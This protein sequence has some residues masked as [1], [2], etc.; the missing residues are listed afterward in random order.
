MILANPRNQYPLWPSS[1]A[2]GQWKRTH[3]YDIWTD[4]RSST[5][6]PLAL[7]EAWNDGVLRIPDKTSVMHIIPAGVPHHVEGVFGYWR[8]CE[9]DIV[10]LRVARGELTHYAMI[11]GGS[12]ADYNKDRILWICPACATTVHSVEIETGRTKL[13]EFW[14]REPAII[15]EFNADERLRTCPNCSHV[16]PRAYPF[17]A[18]ASQVALTPDVIW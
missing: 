9:S 15:N 18:N 14:A 5:D 2:L 8:A 4:C 16:H 7:W 3:D 13:S 17:R 10:W 1:S 6:A 12:A 11:L